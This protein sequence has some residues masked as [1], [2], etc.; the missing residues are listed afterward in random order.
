MEMVRRCLE[1]LTSKDNLF[2]W[3]GKHYEG[4]LGGK[5]KIKLD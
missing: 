2:D 1:Q 3:A 5:I 4:G